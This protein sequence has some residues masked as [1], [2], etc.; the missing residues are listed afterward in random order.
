MNFKKFARKLRRK[1]ISLRQRRPG[2]ADALPT[3]DGPRYFGIGLNKT[4]TST[5]SLCFQQL[6][7]TP[8]AA[9]HSPYVAVAK[10]NREIFLNENY[11]PALETATKFRSFQDRPWNIWRMY[12]RLDEC[13]PESFFILTERDPD[14]WWNSVEKWLTE[15]H[16]FKS[17]KRRDYVRHLK[18][19]EFDR[20]QFISAYIAYNNEVKTYFQG[21][22][23]FRV[24][25][26]GK[27]DGWQELCSFLGVPIPNKTFPHSNRQKYLG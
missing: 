19:Q 25:N 21:R 12:E 10:H 24:M 3:I 15:R 20:D 5:L 7:L 22:Q 16:R 26:F 23:D 27:G 4:G 13:F 18:A 14:A 1:T 8:I 11:Q 2:A 9:P 6:G 17:R